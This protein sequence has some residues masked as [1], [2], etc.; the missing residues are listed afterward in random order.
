MGDVYADSLGISTHAPRTGSDASC[1]SLQSAKTISTHAPRTG[2]D[3]DD[4]T[5]PFGVQDFNP[6]S[7]HGERHDGSQVFF[8]NHAISTHAPRTGSDSIC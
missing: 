5:M 8:R 6:R 3:L 7:P 1:K 4:I 2:S